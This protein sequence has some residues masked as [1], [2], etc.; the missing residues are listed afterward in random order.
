MRRLLGIL[1]L[2]VVLAVS[3][4]AVRLLWLA[5]TFRRISPHFAG[6]CR[7]VP[8]PVGPE[9][10]TIHPR[11]GIAYVSA[12]DRRAVDAKHPV[13]GAIWAYDLNA[14]DAVPV[15]LTPSAD[16]RFQPHGISLWTGPDGRDALFV[17][18][19]PDD[20]ETRTNAVE[21]FDVTERGL[22]HRATLT[23]P[24]LVMP[25]DLVAVGLDRFY[26]TNTHAHPPGA[27]QTIETYL[28]LKG[29][30]VLFYGPGGFRSAIGDLLF[31]NGIN[32]SP[33]GRTLYVASTTG[34]NVRFYDRDPATETLR[35]RQEV[36]VGSGADNIEIDPAGTLWIGTHPKLLRVEAHGK[37]PKTLS[38]SQVLRVT[39]DGTV[40]EVFLDDGSTI[41]ASTVAAVRGDRLLIGNV[42]DGAFLDCT[43]TGGGSS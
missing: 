20:G 42:F 43:M 39:P 13:P 33:D 6:S 12:T 35:L 19:H 9:D 7:A 14:P 37:D 40:D 30:N 11:T 17:V 26:V 1:A 4:W 27:M 32:V 8:G 21:I 2:I 16:T 38:P 5:G 41:S 34:R 25:N 31:P 28:Q 36:G 18:N 15:N 23:D 24:L 22:L 3:V 10:I 29:A